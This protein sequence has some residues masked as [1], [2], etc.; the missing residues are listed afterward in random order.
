M[1]PKNS[2]PYENDAIRI[3]MKVIMDEN[4]KML[5]SPLSGKKFIKNEKLEMYIILSSSTIQIINHKYSYVVY[6]SDKKY[7]KLINFF[8]EE[9][10]KRREIFEKEIM[11]NI[12]YSMKN[13]LN[14]INNEK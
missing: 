2:L 1:E 3:T 13:I 10:E 12:G 9:V 14:S 5:I 8:N 4:S 7:D 6:V 11:S